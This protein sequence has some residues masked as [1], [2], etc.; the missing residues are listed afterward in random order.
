M[1]TQATR[2]DSLAPIGNGLSCHSHRDAMKELDF[3]FDPLRQR[4][5]PLTFGPGP[6]SC[7]GLHL[8]HKSMTVA[9]EVLRERL[10]RVRL[11]DRE[12]ALPR[13]IAPRASQALRVA[14]E[15]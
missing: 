13:G 11:I 8:A 4:A 10:P 2:V 15:R 6:K 14:I 12:A 1:Y 9:L 7:P 5:E 3:A